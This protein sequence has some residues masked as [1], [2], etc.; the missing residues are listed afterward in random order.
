MDTRK[1]TCQKCGGMMIVRLGEFQCT[2]CENSQPACGDGAEPG[3][4]SRFSTAWD[5]VR[6]PEGSRGRLLI[7][8]SEDWSAPP[9][10]KA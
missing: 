4:G 6:H 7:S 2:E 9:P 8:S 1:K 3:G 5:A 10:P